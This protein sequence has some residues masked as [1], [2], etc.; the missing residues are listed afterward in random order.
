MFKRKIDK[1]LSEGLGSQLIWLSVLVLVVLLV[2]WAI[3]AICFPDWDFHWQDVLA[4]FLDPGCFGGKGEHD[5]FRLVVALTG[6]LL[7]ST[8]LISV[9]NNL[10][11][12]IVGLVQTGRRRYP[13]SGHI[14]F[15]GA[16]NELVPV[17]RKFCEAGE[18]RDIVIMTGED[19]G[20]L[21]SMLELELGNRKFVRNLYLYRGRRDVLS[22]LESA[23]A[24]KASLVYIIGD[25][26]EEAHDSGNIAAYRLLYGMCET[27]SDN[28]R[29][30]PEIQCYVSLEGDAAMD[31]LL[32]TGKSMSGKVLKAD[33]VCSED[34]AVEHLLVRQEFLPVIRKDS[35]A[36]AHVVILGTGALAGRMAVVLSHI[37]HYPNYSDGRIRKTLVTV[38]G[39]GVR[40]WS[41][42]FIA[43]NR[44]FMELCSYTS[45][46]ED[47][48]EFR[49]EPSSEYGDFLDM[50]WEFVDCGY[51]SPLF[52]AKMKEWSDAG[53]EGR[54]ELR[55]VVCEDCQQDAEALMLGL[56]DSML[57]CRK[58]VYVR[59]DP[60]L[61]GLASDSGKFGP[62][63]F[64]GPGSA[65]YDPLFEARTFDGMRVNDIYEKAYGQGRSSRDAWYS[66]QEAH[67]ISSI[68]CHYAMPLRRRCYGSDCDEME[69]FECEHRRW[70]CTTLLTGYRALPKADIAEVR[71]SH[72]EKEMKSRFFHADIEPFDNLPEG[73]KEKDKILVDSLFFSKQA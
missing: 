27:S 13:L 17:L 32:R 69:L 14:L 40:V 50:E 58:A 9:F 51:F 15:L 57:A 1:V 46:S 65:G 61:L 59:H 49:H 60:V 23:C 20:E 4:V 7:F 28:S 34:N 30:F 62:V 43:S 48:G 70:M 11:D 42:S 47:G 36:S 21:R 12:N 54:E 3:L 39:P 18:K 71:A 52:E 24:G 29:T 72:K 67:K 6:V 55:L 16:G 45:I 22:D 10:F 2:F 41:E 8:L 31:V 33:F 5:F 63:L 53:E 25:N 56:P 26:G 44:S 73:E 66:L 38:A 19:I 64:F 37:C 35:P 68:Y